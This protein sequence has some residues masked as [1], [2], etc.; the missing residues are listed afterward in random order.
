[1]ILG[2]SK[3]FNV[4]GRLLLFMVNDSARLPVRV[5][6]WTAFDDDNRESVAAAAATNEPSDDKQP[7]DATTE[8]RRSTLYCATLCCVYLN[9]I[10]HRPDM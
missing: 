7:S 2:P 9:L 5:C 10:H 4:K 8:A 3:Q 6:P 1:M